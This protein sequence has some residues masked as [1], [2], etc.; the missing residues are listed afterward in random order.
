MEK[1]IVSSPNNAGRI[2]CLLC[3]LLASCGTQPVIKQAVII[4]EVPTEEPNIAPEPTSIPVEPTVVLLESSSGVLEMNETES[5]QKIIHQWPTSSLLTP[6]LYEGIAIGAPENDFVCDSEYPADWP[7][8]GGEIIL[9]LYYDIPLRPHE[10]NLLL[11]EK[12]GGIRR[13]ELLNSISGL[14]KL[15]FESGQPVDRQK[16]FDGGCIDLVTLPVEAD[17]DV[18]TILISFDSMAEVFQLDAVELVGHVHL[19]DYLPV[20]W[21]VPVAHDS[22]T[23]PDGRYPGGMATNA[24]NMVFLANGQNGLQ[25]FDVE[26]NFMQNYSVPDESYLSDV[27]IDAEQHIA[28]TDSVYHWFI[29]LDREGVQIIAG[30]E[31]FSW[32]N[33][34]AIAINPLNDQICLLNTDDQIS[35]IRVYTYDTAQWV[36][37]IPLEATGEFGY[38]GLAF[39]TEGYLYTLSV[40]EEAIIKIDSDNGEQIDRL[41]YEALR[42]SSVSD[43]D[44]DGE[45]NFYVLM[46][47]SPTNSAVAI[48]NSQGVLTRRFGGLSYDGS[49]WQEGV[50]LF[51]ISLAVTADGRFLFVRENEYLT[52]YWL[53]I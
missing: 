53:E 1:K 5:D 45:G 35:Q 6:E 10:V 46:S 17:F 14:G 4:D 2:I 40:S 29:L 44:I 25:R 33:P 52:A 27:T 26:G 18:D 42:G 22:Q 51:P 32:N 13:V 49:N 8:A 20:F 48:L 31:N 34:K 28:V 7:E 19:Y 23:D 21:R 37:D 43:L 41:G 50:F 47:S 12:S 36:R 38:K 3:L 15:V 16:S 24:M 11:G 9:A 30:G 39:D